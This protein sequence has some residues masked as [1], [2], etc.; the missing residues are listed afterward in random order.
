V[1][2]YRSV[3]VASVLAISIA[4]VGC[5]AEPQAGVSPTTRQTVSPSVEPTPLHEPY[6]SA[7]PT[8]TVEPIPS[9]TSPAQHELVS[10][11]DRLGLADFT[12]RGTADYI[13]QWG[14]G[15]LDGSEVRIYEFASEDEY[16]TYLDSVAPFGI[17]AN[18]FVKQGLYAVAPTDRG[19]LERIRA[20]F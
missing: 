9:P 1:S 5:A 12:L 17:T 20:A 4:V 6:V 15:T 11:A 13:S 16:L 8:P 10:I 3:S 18:D 19:Q 7:P 14:V 2:A